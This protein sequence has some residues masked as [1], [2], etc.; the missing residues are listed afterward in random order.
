MD[1]QV[2]DLELINLLKHIRSHANNAGME[3]DKKTEEVLLA[4]RVLSDADLVWVRDGRVRFTDAGRCTMRLLEEY[5]RQE[6]LAHYRN[7]ISKLEDD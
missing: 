6:M 1:P 7:A 4:V 5:S 2:S 3:L